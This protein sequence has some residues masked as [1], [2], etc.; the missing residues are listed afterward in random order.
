MAKVGS[1]TIVTALTTAAL[2]AI[3]VLAWQASAAQR[4]AGPGHAVPA[5]TPGASHSAKPGESA[6]ARKAKELPVGSGS[7]RRVVY[8]LARHRVWLVAADGKAS[9]T[10][11]VV[12][13]TVSPAP[14]TYTVA[15]AGRIATITGTDGTPIEHVVLFTSVKGTVVG[16]SADVD[17]SL[18][19]PDP[20][21]QT[22]GIREHLADGTAMWQFA[23]AGTKVTVVP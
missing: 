15:S 23:T 16:F 5:A 17:G 22:G 11:E 6:A 1:G 9:R 18:P 7:G 12:P 3:G 19:T 21:K 10:Y 13:G 2:A 8:S 14:G 4:E 20:T